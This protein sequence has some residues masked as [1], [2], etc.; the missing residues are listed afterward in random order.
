MSLADVYRLGRESVD[1]EP[2]RSVQ[3]RRRIDTRIPNP[4]LSA[5]VASALPKPGMG[6]GGLTNLRAGTGGASVGAGVQVGSAWGAGSATSS[7]AATPTGLRGTAASVVGST[8]ASGPKGSAGIGASSGFGGGGARALTSHNGGTV[9][10]PPNARSRAGTRPVS[11]VAPVLNVEVGE[12]SETIAGGGKGK[13]QDGVDDW[14][15]SGDDA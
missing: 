7:R 13:I 9:Y 8:P 15:L 14:E 5:A 4:L 11:P 12:L 3:I 2:N 6:L 10:T 1:Q